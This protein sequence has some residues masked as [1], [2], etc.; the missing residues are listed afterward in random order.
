MKPRIV[1]LGGAESGIGAAILAKK[2]NYDVF[3]SDSGN[4][5]KEYKDVLLHNDI[6]FEEGKHSETFFIRAGEIIKSPGI[7]DHAPV[8]EKIR[9]HQIPVISETEFA[10]RYTDAKKICITGSNGK[11]TTSMLTY[12]ILKKAGFNVGLAGNIGKSFARQVAENHFDYYVLEISSFQLDYMFRFKADIAVITNITQDHLDRY[13]HKF[14]N[15]ID[16]KFRIAQNQSADDFFIYCADDLVTRAELRKRDIPASKIPFSL[17][18]LPEGNGA[19]VK[20]NEMIINVLSKTINMGLENFALPGRHNLYNS[21]AAGIVSRVYGIRKDI[22]KESM[23]E[24]QGVEH[25]LEF[26]T[27]VHGIEFINDSKATNVNSTWFA[28]ESMKRPVIWIVGG[29]DKGNDYSALKPLVKEK[30]KAI[31][32]LGTE[33]TKIIE[34]F[35]SLVPVIRQTTSAEEAVKISYDLGIQ[36][37]VVLLSPACASFDLF[38]NYEDRGMQFKRAVYDL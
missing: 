29:L 14:Q 27:K 20:N 37:D 11:T 28:L 16:S 21:M 30:V 6:P 35:E 31:V 19:Y 12:H 13:D 5:K 23:S 7:S 26:V 15:Y 38:N 17:L 33:N 25:R 32:C 24:F 36:G 4:I 9:A 22:I 8:M 3:V 18:E 34:E 1:I 10:A 2:H